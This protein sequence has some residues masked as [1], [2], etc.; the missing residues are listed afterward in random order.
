[1]KKLLVA[2]LATT[3]MAA[4]AFANGDGGKKKKKKAK[5]EN[6]TTKCDKK[7]D[8]TCCDMQGCVKDQKCVP[9]ACADKK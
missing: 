2:I 7:C 8:P 3:L 9:T 5:T 1:M 4:P 6:K